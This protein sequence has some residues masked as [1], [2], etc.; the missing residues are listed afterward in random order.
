MKLDY[1]TSMEVD[2]LLAPSKITWG[3]QICPICEIIGRVLSER[4]RKYTYYVNH[5]SV[6]IFDEAYEGMRYNI[7]VDHTGVATLSVFEEDKWEPGTAN[8]II[9]GRYHVANPDPLTNP[10]EELTKMVESLLGKHIPQQVL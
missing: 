5:N 1:E 10:E 3:S 8:M 2:K 6:S 4:V 9:I 7:R